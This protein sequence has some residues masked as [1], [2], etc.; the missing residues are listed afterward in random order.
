MAWHR[1]RADGMT[2]DVNGNMAD[3]R[4]DSLRGVFNS[5]LPVVSRVCSLCTERYEVL[6]VYRILRILYS[7]ELSAGLRN[8]GP[9]RQAPDTA[10]GSGAGCLDWAV[11]EDRVIQTRQSAPDSV[12]QR[13]ISES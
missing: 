12:K 1:C 9:W 5:Q 8:L 2:G 6:R 10:H 11:T 4:S 7:P 13:W 3:A